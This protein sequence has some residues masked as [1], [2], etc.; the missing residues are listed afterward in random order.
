MEKKR[1]MHNISWTD[2]DKLCSFFHVKFL[3]SSAWLNCIF[4]EWRIHYFTTFWNNISLSKIDIFNN[5]I[6]DY[7][8]NKCIKK[9]LILEFIVRFKLFN[10]AKW[11]VLINFNCT[12]Y[13]DI[14]FLLILN[15]DFT[16]S[17]VVISLPTTINS[18][19][20]IH[21]PLIYLA[22]PTTFN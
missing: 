17:Y 15:Y 12:I 14:Q 1:N 9:I 18:R 22:I 5:T 20:T 11:N 13:R 4:N 7:K 10:H 6:Y 16:L 21:R 8:E 19:G 2:I 3:F